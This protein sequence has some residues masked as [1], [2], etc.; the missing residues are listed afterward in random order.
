MLAQNFIAKTQIK[1][2]KNFVCILV[3]I[4]LCLNCCYKYKDY[5]VKDLLVKK[6]I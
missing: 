5:F 4:H 2:I 6:S 1:S 3:L